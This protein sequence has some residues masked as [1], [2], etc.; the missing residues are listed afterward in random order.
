[1]GQRPSQRVIS[2][3]I[4][5]KQRKSSPKM[6]LIF[7]V[8]F[9]FFFFSFSIFPSSNHACY[10]RPIFGVHHVKYL[11][12]FLYHDQIELFL[13]LT[14]SSQGSYLLLLW[15]QNCFANDFDRWYKLPFSFYLWEWLVCFSLQ[16][17]IIGI[18]IAVVLAACAFDVQSLPVAYYV[19]YFVPCSLLSSET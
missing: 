14:I 7:F 11:L 1:M 9:S 16:L 17:N 6:W 12:K 4:L 15:S 10:L 18:W 8:K 2:F 3:S 13:L 19:I 5:I